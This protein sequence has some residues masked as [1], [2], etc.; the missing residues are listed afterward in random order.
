M[1]AYRAPGAGAQVAVRGAA[2]GGTA[3]PH[4]RAA[5]ARR[6]S[7]GLTERP[8]TARRA[9]QALRR[10]PGTVEPEAD[11]GGRCR[12]SR[13]L[14]ERP[15]PRSPTSVKAPE[16]YTCALAVCAHSGRRRCV[17][18]AWLRAVAPWAL[19]QR[20]RHDRWSAR[21]A[22]WG[23]QPATSRRRRIPRWRRR[24]AGCA[25]RHTLG[26]LARGGVKGV[27]VPDG[28]RARPVVWDHRERAARAWGARAA[29]PYGRRG[30]EEE[31]VATGQCRDGGAEPAL[32]RT[33]EDA[34]LV[35]A[36]TRYV[37]VWY[38]VPVGEGARF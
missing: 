7:W 27:A 17:V 16:R 14:A 38:A 20:F 5:G 23:D 24:G 15:L 1:L 29:E 19:V 25:S 11:A 35:Y 13:D 32:G 34:R 26:S 21:R 37:S 33:F 31:D 18:L 10:S 8:V 9:A 2:L 30:G 3:E 4:A 6:G 22:P 36:V 28:A 12:R